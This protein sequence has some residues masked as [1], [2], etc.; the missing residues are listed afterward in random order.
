MDAMRVNVEHMH[1]VRV[2]DKRWGMIMYE[3][4]ALVGSTVMWP[5]AFTDCVVEEHCQG[6]L[7]RTH[8]M[9]IGHGVAIDDCTWPYEEPEPEISKECADGPVRRRARSVGAL[10]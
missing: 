6:R 10:T 4:H 3:A 8:L 5:T 2:V 9:P 7:V 1:T